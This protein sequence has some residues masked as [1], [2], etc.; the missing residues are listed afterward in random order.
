MLNRTI[1]EGR[2]VDTPS[3]ILK[4][5]LEKVG[6]TSILH[7][8]GNLYPK[9]I[10][11]FYKTFELILV[12]DLWIIIFEINGR[13]VGASFRDFGTLLNIP[14]EGK[15]FYSN[16]WSLRSVLKHNSNPTNDPLYTKLTHPTSIIYNITKKRLNDFKFALEDPCNLF[17][18]EICPY[19]KD[20]H[21]L[22]RENIM[23]AI[24]CDMDLLL[25]CEAYML[26]CISTS[27]LFNFSHFIINRIN[28]FKH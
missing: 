8:N 3:T 9:F 11:E 22:I 4:K 24:D 19:L 12:N 6:I 7:L 26:Y 2:T 28:D 14:F 16:E 5:N 27:T 20:A 17:V 15:C 21:L 13:R 23:C 10:I 1:H 25:A 18:E